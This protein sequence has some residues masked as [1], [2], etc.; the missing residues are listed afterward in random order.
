MY[1]CWDTGNRIA[2]RF[3]GSLRTMWEVNPPCQTES[4]LRTLMGAELDKC[5]T[6][7][8]E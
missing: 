7:L 8:I 4:G 2:L 5:S 6:R 3:N 1:G